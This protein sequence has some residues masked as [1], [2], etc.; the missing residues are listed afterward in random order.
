MKAETDPAAAADQAAAE[1]LPHQQI[2]ALLG[3]GQIYAKRGQID[4][5]RTA[6][7][8]AAEAAKAD[9][10]IPGILEGDIPCLGRP[11]FKL[12][13]EEYAEVYSTATERLYLLN[14]ICRDEEDWDTVSVDT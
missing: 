6:L 14:W 13:D 12:T 5:A 2:Q 9:G 8:T 7:T 4:D 1:N 3:V 10:T 11:F